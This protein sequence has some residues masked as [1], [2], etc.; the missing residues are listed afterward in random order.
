MFEQESAF[1]RFIRRLRHPVRAIYAFL[2]SKIGVPLGLYLANFFVQR[3]LR[4]NGAAAFQVHYTS[5]IIAPEKI[6]LGD[7]VW[8]SF[9]RSGNCYIQAGNGI[10]IGEY[11]IFAPSVKLI[12]ANH[13]PE[14]ALQ[15]RS[16]TGIV[17]GKHCWIG[18]N[19]VILPGVSIG[20]HSIIGAG[21]VVTRSYGA[22]VTL[23]GIPA[24]PIEAKTGPRNPR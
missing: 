12:S 14:N 22:G 18:T 1:Q 23:V 15:W 7:G 16:E 8:R 3:V 11:T 24:R 17:I 5:T 19:A 2:Q 9:A 20:D 10:A 4:I 21:A 6:T 13:D